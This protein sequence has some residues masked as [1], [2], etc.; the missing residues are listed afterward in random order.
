MFVTCHGIHI[1]RTNP[2][3]THTPSTSQQGRS[4]NLSNSLNRTLR[5]VD[6]RRCKMERAPFRPPKQATQPERAT[7]NKTAVAPPPPCANCSLASR[8]IAFEHGGIAS[9]HRFK[10][11]WKMVCG[12]SIACGITPDALAPG[13]NVGGESVSVVCFLPSLAAHLHLT[14]SLFCLVGGCY[15]GDFFWFRT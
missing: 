3:R 8:P 6:V 9:R 1:A 10:D 14:S 5:G 11:D 2:G 12:W 15:T 7:L 13:Q 4:A